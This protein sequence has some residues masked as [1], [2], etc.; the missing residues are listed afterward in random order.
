MSAVLLH[1]YSFAAFCAGIAFV[2]PESGRGGSG[3]GHCI[4][5]CDSY[6]CG[7]TNYREE[8][9]KQKVSVGIFAG[10]NLFFCTG[11]RIPAGESVCVRLGGVLFDH[12]GVMC[13]RRN[14]GRY[15]ELGS[16]ILGFFQKKYFTNPYFM[17]YYMMI[18]SLLTVKSIRRLY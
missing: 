4:N 16:L 18:I 6:L 10:G 3:C 12:I 5:L 14:A 8:T 7:L 17:V 1:S 13:G 2:W 15:A 9:S 11:N